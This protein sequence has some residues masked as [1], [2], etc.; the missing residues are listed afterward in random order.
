MSRSPL[1]PPAQQSEGSQRHYTTSLVYLNR[2]I[3]LKNYGMFAEEIAEIS[4]GN[5]D[6]TGERRRLELL[7]NTAMLLSKEMQ[8]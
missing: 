7:S 5:E 8:H 4:L 6:S 3:Q 2:I 1:E